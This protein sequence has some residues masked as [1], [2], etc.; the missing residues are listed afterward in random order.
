MS[1]GDC[2]LQ[3]RGAAH[4]RPAA[5]EGGPRGTWPLAQGPMTFWITGRGRAGRSRPLC[6][7]LLTS[8]ISHFTEE[9][10]EAQKG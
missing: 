7:R 4:S 3:D 8:L 2:K 9:T 6:I 10:A 5:G 1:G